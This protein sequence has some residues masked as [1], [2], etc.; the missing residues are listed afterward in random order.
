MRK[1]LILKLKLVNEYVQNIYFIIHN[2]KRMS[3]WV[4]EKC[5]RV[6][7]SLIVSIETLRSKLHVMTSMKVTKYYG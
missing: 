3:G 7:M 2:Y 1:V 4:S 5:E 6:G